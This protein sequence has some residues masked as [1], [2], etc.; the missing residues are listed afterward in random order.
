MHDTMKGIIVIAGSLARKPH[1]G[2][3]TWV[4]LQYLLGFKRLGWDILFLDE[5]PPEACAADDGAACPLDRSRNLRYFVSVMERFGLGSSFSLIHRPGEH[6]AGMDRGEVLARVRDASLVLNVM[7]YLQDEEILS[8]ARRRVLLDIDPGFCQMWRELGQADLLRGHDDYVTIGENIGASDCA[9]PSCGL[10]WITTPQPVVLEQWPPAA[11]TGSSFT[12]VVTWR[13]AYGPVE[14]GGRR[15]GLRVHEFRKFIELPRLTPRRFEL[16]MSI[17]PAEQTDLRLLKANGWSLADPAGVA[18]DPWSYR[19]FVQGSWAEFMV[20]KNMYVDANSG[21]FSDRSICYLA[22]GKPVLA[23]DTGFTRLYPAGEG[24]LAFR[25]LEE[26]VWGVEELTRNYGGHA[27]AA[28][29][30]AE[31]YFD[32]D[33]VLPRLLARLRIA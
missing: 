18:N 10:A 30:I 27:R 8:Q 4:F 1:S 25:T 17:D 23:Q 20:A 16:A 29:R 9:I 12:S 7:G 22:S 28:R 32:S 14:Y 21:W 24:L 3:H 2:G 19:R 13:G 31:E 26:A 11:P 6:A 15:Y 33:I 5:L